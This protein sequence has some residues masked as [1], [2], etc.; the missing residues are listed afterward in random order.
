LDRV[1][2]GS[3]WVNTFCEGAKNWKAPW[4]VGLAAMYPQWV[5]LILYPLTLLPT[6][7]GHG[8]IAFL[9]LVIFTVYV[10]DWWRALLLVLS[11]PVCDML[12]Q[13]Q[14]E[15]ILV[16]AFMVPLKWGIVIASL[17]PPFL[18]GLNGCGVIDH[19]QS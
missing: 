6:H 3:D 8:L 19:G 13:G 7:W 11:F 5:M 18:L 16:L 10:K 1:V 9:S 12:I 14:L 15:G 2:I 4:E 17:K